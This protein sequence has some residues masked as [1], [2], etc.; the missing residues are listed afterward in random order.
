MFEGFFNVA[1]GFDHEL[2]QNMNHDFNVLV[3][4]EK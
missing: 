4:I 2:C 3:F 1:F